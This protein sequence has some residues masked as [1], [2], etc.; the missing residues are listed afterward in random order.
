[1][2]ERLEFFFKGYDGP[3]D[4]PIILQAYH[5][6]VQ[7]DGNPPFFMT[8][9]INRKLLNNCMLDSGVGA[10]MMPLKVMEKLCLKIT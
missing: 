9:L 5:S 10:N 6:R 8:L 3:I 2:K 7:Y 1:V 4:P